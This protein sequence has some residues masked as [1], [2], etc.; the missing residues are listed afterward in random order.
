MRIEICIDVNDMEKEAD[1]WLLALSYKRGTGDGEPYLNLLPPEG[2][3]TL[4][5]VFLQ[6]V[7]ETKQTKNRLHLD[8]YCKQPKELVSK[9]L[10]KGAKLIGESG[11]EG[12]AW[13]QVLADP[14]GNELC[15]VKESE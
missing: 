8:I 11:S 13:W 15:V 3:A 2:S 6:K 7:P 1:F 14:E 10:D 9:L 4:P 5:I 12:D